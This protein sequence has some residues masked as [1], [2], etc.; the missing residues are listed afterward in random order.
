MTL[1]K[2][3]QK[4]LFKE[5]N[6]ACNWDPGSYFYLFSFGLVDTSEK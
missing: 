2:K 4:I 6:K 5:V 1:R 3:K